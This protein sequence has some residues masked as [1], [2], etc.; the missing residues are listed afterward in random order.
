MSKN[1]GGPDHV[2][3]RTSYKCNKVG[4]IAHNCPQN[5]EKA[6]NLS[7]TK[8]TEPEGEPPKREWKA[9]ASWKYS[10]PKDVLQSHKYDEGKEW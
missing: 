6:S 10:E 8:K 4:H 3:T 5:T 1:N 7:G 9:L 2:E